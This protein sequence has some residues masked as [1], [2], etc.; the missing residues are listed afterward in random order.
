MPDEMT[1]GELRNYLRNAPSDMRLR[2]SYCGKELSVIGT[3]HRAVSF[4][5]IVEAKNPIAN[6]STRA[7]P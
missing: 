2:V 5:L 7:K 3:Y 4:C 1:V 6:S